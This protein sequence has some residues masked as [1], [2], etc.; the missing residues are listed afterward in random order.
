MEI[1]G[2]TFFITGG[3]GFIGSIMAETLLDRGAVVV[4]YDNLS[5]GRYEFL[6]RFEGRMDFRFV[7]GDLLEKS[8]IETA[9]RASNA[10]AVVH[11]AANPDVRKGITETDL[12]LKQG[13]LATYNV[14]EAARKSNVK[15]VLF[16][17]SS[18]VY[19]VP[20]L[21]P[22]PE[23]Y[24]P[25]KPISLYG[26]A[27]LASEGLITAFSHLY[28][29]QYYIYRFANVVGRNM[30]HGVIIDF[31]TKL[32]KNAK[33]LEVLGNGQQRKS[34]IDV[35][36]CVEG[37]LYICNKSTSRENIYNLSSH[38]QISVSEIAGLVTSRFAPGAA[39]RYAGGEQGWPGDIADTFLSSKKVNDLGWKPRLNSAEA[40]RSATDYVYGI[41]HKD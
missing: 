40:V 30:T 11:L 39:I 28:G 32:K 13:T 26:A 24:G 18:V 7:E 22:T 31:A 27:K 34:Y 9:L 19:G 21:R 37:M 6:K 35:M 41:M 2:R 20:S 38:D 12:D 25:L 33:E 15:E 3:A 5:S 14:L 17:S 8:S 4:V 10:G 16:S 29:M 23:D 1:K 36:D